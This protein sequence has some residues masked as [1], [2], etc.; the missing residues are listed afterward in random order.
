MTYLLMPDRHASCGSRIQ[1][2]P[3]FRLE[4]GAGSGGYPTPLPILHAR[5][6]WPPALVSEPNGHPTLARMSATPRPMRGSGGTDRPE[7]FGRSTARVGQGFSGCGTAPTAGPM[8]AMDMI[9]AGLRY[10]RLVAHF[11]FRPGAPAEPCTQPTHYPH[12]LR[13]FDVARGNGL[14]PRS[15]WG[16]RWRRPRTHRT[17]PGSTHLLRVAGA[18]AAVR[19]RAELDRT[20]RCVAEGT[21]N[22]GPQ[23][24]QSGWRCLWL[25]VVGVG[26]PDLPELVDFTEQFLAA[27]LGNFPFVGI[28]SQAHFG[29]SFPWSAD[30][31]IGLSILCGRAAGDS[32][33]ATHTLL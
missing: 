26:V 33:I 1:T 10:Q 21:Q 28:R 18:I 30:G 4:R 11:H 9:I 13:K 15:R 31:Q 2:R 14:D 27:L 22:S 12:G 8:T 23:S 25:R 6:G 24:A 7:V 20:F 3:V 17:G 19:A 16:W 29:A 32:T 5:G